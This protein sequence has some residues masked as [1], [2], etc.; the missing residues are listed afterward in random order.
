MKGLLFGHFLTAEGKYP[1]FAG[2]VDDTRGPRWL[3][4]LAMAN[5]TVL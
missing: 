5:E 1:R 3:N 2:T 4:D